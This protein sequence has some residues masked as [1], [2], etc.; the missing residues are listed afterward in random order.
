MPDNLLLEGDKNDQKYGE[1]LR[2]E[3]RNKAP[4]T[5]FLGIMMVNMLMEEFTADGKKGKTQES[6]KKQNAK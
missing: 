6:Q 5:G 1:D 2:Q 3:M 4:V